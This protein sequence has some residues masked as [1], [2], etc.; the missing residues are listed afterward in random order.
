VTA[1]TGK[2]GV[3]KTTILRLLLS[4]LEPKSGCVSIYNKD[5]IYPLDISTRCSFSYVPQGNTL[6]S[7]SIKSNLLL[8]NPKASDEEIR[9]ALYVS[10]ADFVYNLPEGLDTECGE[11][12]ICLSEGQAQRIA[13][14]RALLQSR[15]IVLLDE[16]S[17]S[18]DLETEI[19]LM[20]RLYSFL[21]G[22]TVIYITHRKEVLKYCDAELCMK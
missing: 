21:K 2:T 12:S 6:L 1:I 11:N 4:F 3:G 15:P 10:V 14:A 8:A 20:E 9:K 18:L 13:I 16:I 22:K 7:G 19:L 5:G 17:S